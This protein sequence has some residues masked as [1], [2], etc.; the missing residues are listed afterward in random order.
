MRKQRRKCKK[1]KKKEKKRKTKIPSNSES[2]N[3][4]IF[5]RVKMTGS[6]CFYN[7][8]GDSP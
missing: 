8:T 1:K 3:L 4:G 5:G 2:V 6:Q 7:L